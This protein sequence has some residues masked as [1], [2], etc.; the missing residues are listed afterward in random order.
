MWYGYKTNFL[1]PF[2]LIEESCPLIVLYWCCWNYRPYGA[3][4]W[5]FTFFLNDICW[6]STCVYWAG[7]RFNL[8]LVLDNDFL[9]LNNGNPSRSE[10]VW[11]MVWAALVHA[12]F[13]RKAMFSTKF[14]ILLSVDVLIGLK[15]WNVSICHDNQL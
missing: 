13:F 6:T 10:A 9:L 14:I 4:Y 5:T 12:T 2:S 3:T 8:Y 15:K 1:F 7:E 11:S